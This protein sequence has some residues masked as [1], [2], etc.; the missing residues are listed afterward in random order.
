MKTNYDCLLLCSFS[1]TIFKIVR[2]S[3]IAS[4]AIA[5]RASMPILVEEPDD[6]ESFPIENDCLSN[7]PSDAL[8]PSK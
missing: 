6:A 1:L 2:G 4:S 5:P 7:I 3:T 8:A